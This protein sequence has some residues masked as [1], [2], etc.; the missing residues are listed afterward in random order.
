[1]EINS[2]RNVPSVKKLAI[3]YMI[4]QN[5]FSHSYQAIYNLS[6]WK[7]YGY[8]AFFRSQLFKS[9]ELIFQIAK[10]YNRLI[11]LD[12]ASIVNATLPFFCSQKVN[13]LLFVNIFPSTLLNPSFPRILESFVSIPSKN[14]VFEINESEKI[15]DI[16]GLRKVISLI[17]ESGYYIAFDDVGKEQTSIQT[18]IEFESDFIKLDRYFSFDLANSVKK[19]NFLSLLTSYCKNTTTLILEGIETAEDLD[20][21][22]LV[23]IPLG[24]G[25]ILGRETHLKNIG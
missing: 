12:T 16:Q 15:E 18:L 17:R 10:K 25:Y 6:T 21:A 20:M 1:M 7:T 13:G 24:Q 8:E 23:G 5:H 3:D 14:I 2:L 11:E 4:R 9:P 19:Q 22:K